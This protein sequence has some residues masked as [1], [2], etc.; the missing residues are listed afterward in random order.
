MAVAK[1]AGWPNGFGRAHGIEAGDA[2]AAPVRAASA[3]RIAERAHRGASEPSGEPVIAHVRRVA[4][5]SPA[6]ARAVAW[7]HEVFEYSSIHEEEL[8]AGG[9]TDEELLALRLLTRSDESRSE[10]GYLA[11]VDAILRAAGPGGD[12]AR[13]VKRL[14]LEDRVH[15]PR[16]R[17]DGWHPPYQTGLEHLLAGLASLGTAAN[18]DAAREP[19]S[20]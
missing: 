3:R 4:G 18:R 15:H 17:P 5:A 7:L 13:T 20:S 19:F 1:R 10:A 9:L 11:H 14:D 2:A 16:R 12:L 6:S 8:L